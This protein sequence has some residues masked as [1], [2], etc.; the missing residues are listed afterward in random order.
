VLIPEV[1]SEKALAPVAAKILERVRAVSVPRRAKL[2]V[3]TSVG[4]AV[5]PRDGGDAQALLKN[6]DAA[7]Y[8][9]KTAGKDRY[10]FFSHGGGHR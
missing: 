7:L 9:A 8:R 4:I 2:K 6:A 1:R 10:E 5:Y 3:T